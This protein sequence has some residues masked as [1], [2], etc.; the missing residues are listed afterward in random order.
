MPWMVICVFFAQHICMA[1]SS[2]DVTTLLEQEEYQLAQ[3]YIKQEKWPEAVIVLKSLNNHNPKKIKHAL[4]LSESLVYLG[5]REEALNLLIQVY[6]KKETTKKNKKI[7]VDKIDVLSQ[8]FMTNL[9]FQSYQDALS[10]MKDKKFKAALK[11]FYLMLSKEPKNLQILMR[12]GQSHFFLKQYSMA[13][14]LFL[15]AKALNP[16]RAEVRLW[17]GKSLYF[18]N[19]FT[20][21]LKELKTANKQLKKSEL[22]PV[23]LSKVLNEQGKLNKAISVLEQDIKK[24]STHVLSL[25]E[26]AQ[27]KLQLGQRGSVEKLW[28]SRQ[29]LQL[30]LSRFKQYDKNFKRKFYESDLDYITH[31]PKEIQ[32]KIQL[33]LKKVDE[34]VKGSS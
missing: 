27:L 29:A 22:A 25:F 33:L 4:L 13:T 12:I 5:R 14:E 10:K 2:N 24:E 34:K 30:A 11:G 28:E 18:K 21:A 15:E 3:T 7:L 23:W 19:Q 1:A 31:N 32:K 9:T 8:V 20:R 17:L 26:L 16:H 6:S